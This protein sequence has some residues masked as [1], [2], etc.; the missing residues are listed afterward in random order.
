[1]KT[2]PAFLALLLVVSFFMI[3]SCKDNNNPNGVIDFV[4]SPENI[5]L[6][7]FD[8]VLLYLS[9]KP[10]ATVNW[11]A[12]ASTNWIELQPSSGTIQNNIQEIKVISNVS[13]LDERDYYSTIEIISSG[14]GK[15]TA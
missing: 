14:A 6:S 13:G 1:M 7:D 5:Y 4:L 2:F 11:Q 12:S 9:T 15:G 3:E 8:T 10:S